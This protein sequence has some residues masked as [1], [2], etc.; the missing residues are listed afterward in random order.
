MTSEIAS[1]PIAG[2]SKQ[3]AKANDKHAHFA[4]EMSA[5]VN[6]RTTASGSKSTPASRTTAVE[7]PTPSKQPGT[8]AK[9]QPRP[10][11]STS[12][13]K[14]QSK[15]ATQST[16]TKAGP[17][18]VISGAQVTTKKDQASR[19]PAPKAPKAS[20]PAAARRPDSVQTPVTFTL[21]VPEGARREAASA[22]KAAP[23]SSAGAGPSQNDPIIPFSSPASSDARGPSR[24]KHDDR[25]EIDN[26][27]SSVSQGQRSTAAKQSV[28]QPGPVPT[29]TSG[30][31]VLENES[32][33]RLQERI[34]NGK[35][36]MIAITESMSTADSP[37]VP[38]TQVARPPFQPDYLVDD[39]LSVAHEM[40]AGR[41]D[42]V[43]TGVSADAEAS[44]PDLPLEQVSEE[45]QGMVDE[46]SSVVDSSTDH[47]GSLNPE[48]AATGA[49][50]ESG[51]P[52]A[53]ENQT[54][55]TSR[56]GSAV[57]ATV[58]GLKKKVIESPPQMTVVRVCL[59]MRKKQG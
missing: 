40:M 16:T 47:T 53:V 49:S 51:T 32:G 15:L 36:V 7:T 13:Q 14:Q 3:P 39:L 37:S 5:D 44:M 33:V 29:S 9:Q 12:G 2:P 21:Y 38:E 42:S 57:E 11:S 46:E 1:S 10:D 45:M 23:S 34:I 8:S 25:E 55:V 41:P 18:V 50:D 30:R 58:R 52:I 28:T 17:S 59:V 4:P 35:T 48:K 43:E 56:F 31:Q 6:D 20:K 22:A 24:K 19:P 54:P 27:D 26:V